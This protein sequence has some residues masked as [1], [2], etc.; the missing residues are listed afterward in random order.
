MNSG[1]WFTAKTRAELRRRVMIFA[2][3]SRVKMVSSLE[4]SGRNEQR[5]EVVEVQR[6]FVRMSYDLN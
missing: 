3:M 6:N 5:E 1:E 2:E 4:K